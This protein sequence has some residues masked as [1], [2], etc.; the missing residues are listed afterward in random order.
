MKL[1]IFL[2]FIL[3]ITT[4]GF[5]QE[6]RGTIGV[7]LSAGA[8]NYQGDLDDNFTLVFTKPGFG[9]HAIVL[10]F[11]RLHFKITA[12]HGSISANDA[13]ASFTNN[14]ARNLNFYSTINE[15][16]L[17]I[18]YSLQNRRRGFSKRNFAVPYIFAGVAYFQFAPKRK[19]NGKEY[20]LQ[21]VGTEGQYL[22]GNYPKPYKLQQLSIPIGAGFKIRVSD[23]FDIGAETGFRKTFTDYL[24][25]VSNHY[26]DKVALLNAEGPIAV[27][28]SDSSTEGKASFSQRGNSANNDWYVYT[29]IHITYYMTTHLFKE[30]KPKNQYKGDTC[31]GLFLK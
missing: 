8:M 18:M 16:G 22:D 15:G 27:Y 26:P 4:E 13:H 1:F 24:D 21:S 20:D 7:G 14:G 31:K 25:D 23:H 30:I 19:I 28:L 9:A 12:L 6:R 29:N 2:F 17:Q 3:L 5:A 10:L 11:P